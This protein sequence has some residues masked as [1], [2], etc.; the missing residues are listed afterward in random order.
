MANSI[1]ILA[2]NLYSGLSYL[3]TT[4]TNFPWATFIFI[5]EYRVGDWVSGG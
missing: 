5:S 1:S 3:F 2:G 4:V